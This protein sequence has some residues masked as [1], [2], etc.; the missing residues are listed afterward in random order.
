MLMS[1]NNF[2]ARASLKRLVRVSLIN[3]SLPGA[4][5]KAKPLF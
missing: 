1:G 4:E 3:V 5:E 2:L